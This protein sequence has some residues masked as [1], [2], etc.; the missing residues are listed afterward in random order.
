MIR[1]CARCEGRKVPRSRRDVDNRGRPL[2]GF[3]GV[4]E[5]AF[6]VPV[7]TFLARYGLV[8]PWNRRRVHA[9]HVSEYEQKYLHPHLI[10]SPTIFTSP[11]HLISYYFAIIL[12]SRLPPWTE[13]RVRHNDINAEVATC[14]YLSGPPFI[15]PLMDCTLDL[16]RTA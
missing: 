7:S 11:P 16:Y 10:S 5:F 9:Q 2:E 1:S 14:K 8:N 3:A 15:S 12:I 4:F 6:K 13:S